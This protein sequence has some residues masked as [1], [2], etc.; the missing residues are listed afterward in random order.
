MN[1]KIAA[2]R[3]DSFL[4]KYPIAEVAIVAVVTG[5]INYP[6]VFMRYVF[7]FH[8]HPKDKY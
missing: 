5:L 2:W 3:R 7:S 6:T 8:P 4:K 1:M